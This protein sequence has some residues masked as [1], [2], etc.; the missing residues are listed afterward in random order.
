MARREF[1]VTGI[2]QGVGFRPFV[3][4][5][6]RER[7]LSGG[8]LNNGRGVFI[9]VEGSA[10]AID[11]FGNDLVTKT[12]PL[13]HIVS[14]ESEDKEERGESGFIIEKSESSV[15]RSALISPDCDVCPDC[16]TELFDPSD[17]RYRYPFTNCA[18]CGPRY[19]IVLD[20]PYDRPNTTMADFKLC[21][22]CREEYENPEE[23]RFH[24]QPVACPE[25]GPTL[26]FRDERFEP[27]AGVD[28]VK[29]G[30]TAIA[31]GGIVATK[32]IGGYHLAVDANNES[33]VNRLR[34]RKKR[35]EKPFALMVSDLATAKT[36]ARIDTFTAGLMESVPHPIVLAEKLDTFSLPGVAPGCGRFGIMLPYTPLHHLILR[37]GGFTALV[38]TSANLSDDPIVHTEEEA[39]A[40]LSGIADAYLTH[41]RAIEHRTDDSVELPMTHGPVIIRRSRGYTPTPIL[42]DK[43][44]P[45]T[46]AM[47]GDLKNTFC[48]IKDDQAFIS[49]HIGDLSWE[50]SITYLE[51]SLDRF[52]KL[53]DAGQP[54]VVAFDKHPDSAGGRLAKERYGSAVLVPVQHHHAHFVSALVERG[55]LEGESIGIVFD[56]TG[57]GDDGAIWG[58]EF[59]TGSAE[60]F[61]RA[62]AIDPLPLPGGDRAIKEPWRIAIA[63]IDELYGE[64]HPLQNAP[65]VQ[66]I[67][68]ETRRA[69]LRMYHKGI[70][71][72]L[73]H[74]AGR[75][76]D[77]AAVLM[78]LCV[79]AGFEGQPV[80]ALEA[81]VEPEVECGY[82]V[83]IEEKGNR[84]NL[85]FRPAFRGVIADILAKTPPGVMATRFHNTVVEGA[86][87]MAQQIR[88]ASGLSRLVLS[89]GCFQNRYLSDTL[90]SR[91]TNSGFKVLRHGRVPPNDGGI[92]LGQ[93]I[94][95][96][97]RM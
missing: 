9:H 47:G 56:G 26:V 76:F 84:M 73:S 11:R 93:A 97:R 53:I 94:V 22:K 20:V 3:Y 60:G 18:N 69:V 83:D 38:M 2:V 23:R 49:Q 78:G 43:A 91:L 1:S 77:V 58:G 32:G 37:E 45:P 41:D 15:E 7:N 59:L 61:V 86:F 17:R 82:P 19:S 54:Q 75:V 63:L 64:D 42:L 34:R 28:S 39:R 14:V 6:A 74:G 31:D 16:L 51:S 65:W 10:E 89:G 44:Y 70:N 27:V 30:V 8:V 12:P 33:A 50:R 57:Y 55:A 72:P 52:M 67:P 24:A 92:S 85:S 71:T 25:C 87:R 5:I 96:A 95:A 21:K 40:G 79:N 36:I 88:G 66:S 35:D 46:L 29:A 80:M 90:G 81:L 13:A 62:G 68:E 4:R 48:V